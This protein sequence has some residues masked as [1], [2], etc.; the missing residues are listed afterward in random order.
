MS[1]DWPA[2]AEK[3]KRYRTLHAAPDP[4]GRVTEVIYCG[5][6]AKLSELT[7]R[8]S[9][10]HGG[11]VAVYVDTL[12]V[13]T[14]A[15]AAS[16]GVV[17]ARCV[18]L[19]GLPGGA[20]VLQRP[21]ADAAAAVELLVGEC[22][23]GQLQCKVSGAPDAAP[24]W[25]VPTGMQ[26]LQAGCYSVFTGGA[27]HTSVQADD[28]GLHDLLDHTWALNSLR[29]SLAAAVWLCD[30]DEAEG[31]T[32]ARSMLRWVVACTGKL[33]DSK[34]F[35]QDAAELQRQ[36]S[37]LLVTMDVAKGV[38]HVPVLSP[39]F[40]DAQVE[41]LLR[42]L[43]RYEAHAAA[44][45][46]GSGLQHLMAHASAAFEAASKDEAAPLQSQLEGI[47][48]GAIAAKS[49]VMALSG[50]VQA[51]L[52]AAD[53]RLAV[54]KTKI[55][56]QR[57]MQVLEASFTLVVNIAKMAF[58]MA[59]AQ[60][61]PGDALGGLLGAVKN[62]VDIASIAG[63]ELPDHAL[64]DR[65]IGLAKAQA[66]ATACYLTG[67]AL[68]LAAVSD[69]AAATPLLSETADAADP[70]AAWDVFVVEVEA[71]LTTLKEMIGSGL[72]AGAAQAAA[73]L[74]LAT[75]KT[76][77]LYAKAL[78]AKMLVAAAQ[79]AQAALLQAQI[80]AAQT[81]S[82]RW[83][84]I[85]ASARSDA[86]RLA[87]L[88][89]MA[90]VRMDSVRRALFTAWVNYR[91]AYYYLLFQEPPRA[92]RPD[93]GSAALSEA[94]AD[95][96]QWVA[97]LQGDAAGAPRVHLPDEN[98]RVSY[99]FRIVTA[100][101][102]AAPGED[103]ALFRPRS[104]KDPAS[105][106]WTIPCGDAQMAGVL[107]DGRK[108]AVWIE[109]A[110]FFVEGVKPNAKGNVLA[111]VATSGVYRNGFGDAAAHDFVTKP[112]VGNYAYHAAGQRVYNRW[113]INT[114]VYSTPSPF[115]QWTMSFDD[116]GGDP[117]AATELRMDLRVAY[118]RAPAEPP[119]TAVQAIKRD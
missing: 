81:T 33:A 43:T 66:Q 21:V 54:L 47:Q 50:E 80:S 29:A 101:G 14:A 59:G 84:A 34:T 73:N 113:A 30:S 90:Q 88:R 65:A 79:A 56:S 61:R 55:D 32:T 92:V 64:I 116:E 8:I 102:V 11:T 52:I 39:R 23:G 41:S 103:T 28:E 112:L 114:A 57:G 51:H 89:G 108:V 44:L 27:A 104:G 6:R 85:R 111:E 42:A 86:E 68:A 99:V 26:P 17:V 13:D 48:K 82:K 83:E 69:K 72:G 15:L 22:R 20:V 60:P 96:R 5:L 58:S 37:G 40:Y 76:L 117:S 4:R 110:R 75:L 38:Y 19:S 1:I 97:S 70:G 12:V 45:E 95:V 49:E 106:I 74:F 78:N 46:T 91:N 100:G 98:V 9:A 109:E 36:A 2:L 67:T 119:P 77:G 16:G 63:R 105:L 24:A 107:P 71:A 93:M 94:F 62:A 53:A 118:R 31:R 3:T 18:D 35:A 10:D 7:A 87:A 115:T 25:T